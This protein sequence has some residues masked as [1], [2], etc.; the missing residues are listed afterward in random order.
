MLIDDVEHHPLFT[1]PEAKRWEIKSIAGFP[2]K[3]A[4]LVL[5]VLNSAF[6]VPH[7]FKEEERQALV[8]LADQAALAS[9][10]ASLYTRVGQRVRE[11]DSLY[12]M[13]LKVSQSLDPSVL[14]DE[15]LATFQAVM[16]VAAGMIL[17]VDDVSSEPVLAA[18]RG[19]VPMAFNEVILRGDVVR[20]LA[21][22]VL[23]S[24]SPV[25][26][27]SQDSAASPDAFAPGAPITSSLAA[28][29]LKTKERILGSLQVVRL[30]GTVSSEADTS[31]LTAIGQ[32]IPIALET[33]RL[34]GQSQWRAD[35][36]GSLRELGLARTSTL[37]L[38]EQLR[39]LYVQV[40]RLLPLDT[41]LIGLY[42]E[43][44]QEINIQFVVEEGWEL[45][46]P[47]VPFD[48]AGLSAWV[49]RTQRPFRVDDVDAE[50]DRL[51]APPRHETRPS[52]SWLGVP[53]LVRDR[54]IGIVS[55][56]SF[57]PHAFSAADERFLV[58][59]AQQAVL[60]FESSRLYSTAERRARELDLLNEISHTITSSRDIEDRRNNILDE[61]E[62]SILATLC[63]QI[64]I[65][66]ANARRYESAIRRERLATSLRRVGLELARSL[67]PEAVIDTLCEAS[68]DLMNADSACV[69]MVEGEEFVVMSARGECHEALVGLRAPPAC[70][71][72]FAQLL[73]ER[74]A[75]LVDSNVE[76][77]FPS[78]WVKVISPR[79]MIAAP[80]FLKDTVACTLVVAFR[81]ESGRFETEDV[82]QVGQL[83]SQASAALA[84][85]WQYKEVAQRAQLIS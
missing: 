34:Y 77:V 62:T 59:V 83:R 3:K 20:R 58:S 48:A 5:G 50:R 67:D 32:Q 57:R 55:A 16:Q 27:P 39:A 22:Q 68:L 70:P 2:I 69:W 10:N 45:R 42:D 71:G 29:P 11:L 47:V 64:G 82:E 65:A 44:R 21:G 85:A 4:G 31:L 81:R 18:Q 9:E 46:G 75:V 8:A 78:A 37:D 41:F 49:I 25:V 76:Q 19:Q 43:A 84:N 36:L 17:L 13:S 40:K 54:V 1:T 28:V 53:L 33:A 26:F 73:Q 12:Q 61:Q 23:K 6:N 80:I 79:S 72:P 52:K 30:D 14:L 24:G 35:E 63:D 60:A 15:A 66:A 74:K 51:P 56:Q 38:R 7:Q